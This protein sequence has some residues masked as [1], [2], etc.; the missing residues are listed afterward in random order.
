M[1]SQSFA[2]FLAGVDDT[3]RDE[4]YMAPIL[5]CLAANEIEGAEELEGLVLAELKDLPDARLRGFLVRAQNLVEAK[6][7]VKQ[8]APAASSALTPEVLQALLPK[9]ET[10][11]H[12]DIGAKL[13]E[14]SVVDLCPT[15]WPNSKAA[16]QLLTEVG[17]EKDKGVKAPF[18]YAEMRAFLPSWCASS[19]LAD[20]DEEE[21]ATATKERCVSN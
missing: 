19:A 9:K 20:N 5:A 15:L 16:D 14:V 13:G 2:D 1:V 17:K 7:A 6:G 18:V 11:K 8:T 3:P 21:E 12:L 4:V 10:K